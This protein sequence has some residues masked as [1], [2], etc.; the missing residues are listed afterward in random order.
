MTVYRQNS[1]KT[2]QRAPLGH[3]GIVNAPKK[4]GVR[5]RAKARIAPILIADKATVAFSAEEGGKIRCVY[6]SWDAP[7]VVLDW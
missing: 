5:W 4:R 3:R 6:S 7:K 2:D 1:G